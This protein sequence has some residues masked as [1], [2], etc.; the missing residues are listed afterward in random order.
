MP[1]LPK[2]RR[3]LAILAKF[4]AERG[5]GKAVTP[6]AGRGIFRMA[7]AQQSG[8]MVRRLHPAQGQSIFYRAGMGQKG[9]RA[10]EGYAR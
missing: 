9:G 10:W 8:Q 6:Q 7:K 5:M 3:L 1:L 2:Q 4:R